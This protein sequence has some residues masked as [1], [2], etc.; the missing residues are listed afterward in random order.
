MNLSSLRNILRR[1]PSKNGLP[2]RLSALCARLPQDKETRRLV[3]IGVLILS[4]YLLLIP[5]Y[6]YE[7][8]V[9]RD[10]KAARAKAG[11]MMSLAQDYRALRR[12]VDAVES[13]GSLS[14]QA[15]AIQAMDDIVSGLG[16]KSKLKGIK[17]LGSRE[18]KGGL[19]EDGAELVFEKLSTNEVVNLLHRIDTA[20]LMISVRTASI[21]MSFE[22]Q[23]ALDMT[24]TVALF[25]KKTSQ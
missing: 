25:A 9:E 20:P 17:G 18:I 15:G 3:F 22:N 13:R 1:A 11:D 5:N 4:L 24:L 14:R 6:L 16:L 7:K 8:S 12:Q 21:R 23:N 10:L 19:T 2:H